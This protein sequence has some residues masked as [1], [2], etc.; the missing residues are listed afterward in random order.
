[1]PLLARQTALQPI[2][3]RAT[4]QQASYLRSQRKNQC[5]I[6]GAPFPAPARQLPKAFPDR[7]SWS[8][9][10]DFSYGYLATGITTEGSVA[11]HAFPTLSRDENSS[12]LSI[13]ESGA[14]I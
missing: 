6:F 2:A 10:A 1:M 4:L 13:F 3:P 12:R 5:W 14:T 9:V 7:L 11:V 8:V